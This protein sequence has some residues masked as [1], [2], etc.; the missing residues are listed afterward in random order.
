MKTMKKKKSSK[1]MMGI[2]KRIGPDLERLLKLA[3]EAGDDNPAITECVR[4]G[5]RSL[6]VARQFSK[7]V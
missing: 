7:K 6:L 1:E 5:A 2:V 4:S 3:E